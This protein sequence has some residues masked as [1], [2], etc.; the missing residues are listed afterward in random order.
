VDTKKSKRA[1]VRVTFV[2]PSE[3]FNDDSPGN[4]Y[5][6]Q[7]TT[8]E[9]SV[10]ITVSACLSKEDCDKLLLPLIPFFKEQAEKDARRRFPRIR[11]R[12]RLHNVFWRLTKKKP[13]RDTQGKPLREKLLG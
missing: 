13:V 5:W 9:Y 12:V 8:F 1:V 3:E 4:G 2:C 7:Y 10:I 6:S 11:T